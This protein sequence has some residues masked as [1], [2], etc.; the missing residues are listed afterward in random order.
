MSPDQLGFNFWVV[1]YE[2]LN[3]AREIG[4]GTM[5]VCDIE[6]IPS[7]L[8]IHGGHLKVIRE[9]IVQPKENRNREGGTLSLL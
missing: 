5:L 4:P 3:K 6:A 1:Q 8:S 9:L 7:L 2:S